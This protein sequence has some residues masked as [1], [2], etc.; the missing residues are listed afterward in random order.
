[1]ETQTN[2]GRDISKNQEAVE[3]STKITPQEAAMIR[4]K[5]DRK[6]FVAALTEGTL[7]CLPNKDGFT[8]TEP[9]VN[10]TNG[11]YYHGINMLLLKQNQKANNYPTAE[12]LTFEAL[13]KVNKKLDLSFSE[14]VK[15]NKGEKAYTI[16]YKDPESH[17]PKTVKIFNI[18]QTSNPQKIHDY[19]TI[20]KYEKKESK[21]EYFL[22]QGKEYKPYPTLSNNVAIVECT[23]SSPVEYLGQY[24][25]AVSTRSK[26]KVSPELASEFIKNMTDK[27]YERNSKKPS[28]NHPEGTINPFN[29][30]IIGA[31]ANAHCKNILQEKAQMR[32]VKYAKTH[33]TSKKEKTKSD[34]MEIGM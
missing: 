30:N 12:Y 28:V 21:K 1:M 11:T 15:I 19:T 31:N 33:E 18:A 17:E 7:A 24:F 6:V 8:D 13:N 14:R 3:K 25:A 5:A 4:A 9:V 32:K 26:F 27:I 22:K 23:S 34:L 16:S 10:I 29:L 2:S 20:I